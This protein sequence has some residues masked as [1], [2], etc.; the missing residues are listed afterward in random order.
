MSDDT[1]GDEES[2][3]KKYEEIDRDC[4]IIVQNVFSQL[5]NTD[6][7]S[8]DINRLAAEVGAYDNKNDVANIAEHVLLQ[9]H[10]I[11][12]DPRNNKVKLTALGREN[13]AK[14]IYIP[15][16]DIQKLRFNI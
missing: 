7:Q 3:E 8:Q 14:G 9:H 12:R 5:C 6:P 2:I 16:S 13:C 10:F 1:T 11:E 15:P 4:A